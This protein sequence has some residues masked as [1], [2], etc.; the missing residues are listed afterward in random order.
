[1]RDKILLQFLENYRDH[2][3]LLMRAGL[4]VSFIVH[5]WPKLVGGA[6]RWEK[7]GSAMGAFGI[8]FGHTMFGLLAS[9]TEF[10]GGILLILGLLTRPVLIPLIF[11]MFVATMM[12]V[13][14]GHDMPKIL[15][16]LEVGLAFVGLLFVGPGRFSIDAWLGKKG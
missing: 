9:V 12:H 2:G 8:D 15:H 13:T 3:L 6:E 14:Q 1:M 4:G 16:P 10:G 7:V 11:T 5:G